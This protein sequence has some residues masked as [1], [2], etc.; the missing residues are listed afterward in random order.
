MAIEIKGNNFLFAWDHNR[1]EAP[2]HTCN[3][4]S[5]FFEIIRYQ[6]KEIHIPDGSF[7]WRVM[8]NSGSFLLPDIS[9]CPFCGINLE[10]EYQAA[11]NPPEPEQPGK[12][13]DPIFY[14]GC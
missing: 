9:N 7:F 3:R 1:K 12:S 11:I 14:Y 5:S 4:K 8:T 13:V 2:Y 10:R 6:Y